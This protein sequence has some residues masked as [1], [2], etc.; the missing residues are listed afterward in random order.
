MLKLRPC[1]CV[2]VRACRSCTV[3]SW[4][5]HQTWPMTSVTPLKQGRPG[6]PSS[7]GG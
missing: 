5:W 4:L 6:Q 3:I 7:S 1:V 2:C